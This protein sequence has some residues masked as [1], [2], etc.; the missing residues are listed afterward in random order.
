MTNAQPLQE[1]WNLSHFHSS[2]NVKLEPIYQYLID[3]HSKLYCKVQN[4]QK[5]GIKDGSFFFQ[6]CGWFS[7]FFNF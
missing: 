7:F 2:C 5:L 1:I 4:A 3:C 6:I